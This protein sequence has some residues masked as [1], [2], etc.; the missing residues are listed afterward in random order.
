VDVVADLPADPWSSEPVQQGDGLL[1]DPA[2]GAQ[3]GA[4]PDARVGD[5]RGDAPDLDLVA[6]LVVVVGPVGV[7]L[8]RALGVD[9]R[10]GLVL[11]G[12]P[13][14]AAAVG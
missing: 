9:L 1:D 12:S 10:G 8:I 2:V 5:D 6:V 4:V 3:A 14:S 7:D 13:R 11:V